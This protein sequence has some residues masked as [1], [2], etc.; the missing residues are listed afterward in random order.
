[1]PA[2]REHRRDLV[3]E[4]NDARRIANVRIVGPVGQPASGVERGKVAAVVKFPRI[5]VAM[6]R[7]RAE[8]AAKTADAPPLVEKEARL[9]PVTNVGRQRRGARA[10]RF[11]VSECQH[12]YF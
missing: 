1:V 3:F 8:S 2:R 7:R 5:V 9:R 4:T 6:P 10:A 12:F 11:H